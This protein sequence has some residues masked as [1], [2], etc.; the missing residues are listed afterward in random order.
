AFGRCH[1]SPSR[2]ATPLPARRSGVHTRRTPHGLWREDLRRG[3]PL[4][5][6]GYLA[7]GVT[8]MPCQETTSVSWFGRIKRS[9]A[10]LFFGI[11]MIVGMVVLLFWNEGRAVATARS[12]AEGAGMVVSVDANHADPAREGALVHVSGPVA[13]N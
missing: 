5:K 1:S 9:L 6:G 8:R 11:L 2:A 13:T 4:R 10:G 12:L 7:Q 3:I